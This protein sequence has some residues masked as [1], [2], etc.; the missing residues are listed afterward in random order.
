MD[1]GQASIVAVPFKYLGDA[2]TMA[3]RPFLELNAAIDGADGKEN[4][5][6][7]TSDPRL[8]SRSVDEA[9]AVGLRRSGCARCLEVRGGGN[10][11][12]SV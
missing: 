4:C 10:P 5:G 7:Q 2:P 11:A 3:L 12:G 1:S 9:F 8:A 6:G